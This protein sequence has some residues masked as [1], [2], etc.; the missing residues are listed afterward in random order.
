MRESEVK[1]HFHRFFFFAFVFFSSF[2]GEWR[3]D[4]AFMSPIS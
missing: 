4:K 2:F 1:I 3:L